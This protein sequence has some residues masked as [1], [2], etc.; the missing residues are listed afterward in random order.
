M[1]T[2]LGVDG[3]RAGWLVL[4]WRRPGPEL[5]VEIAPDWPAVLA[6]RRRHDAALVAVDMPIG[7]ADSGPRHCDRAARVLLPKGRKSCVFAAPR[8]YMLT[9]EDWAEAQALG[10]RREGVGLSKQAWNITAKIADIDRAIAPADQAVVREA[11]P[12]LVFHHLNGWQALPPKRLAAGRAARLALL[13][14]AG[15]T[16]IEA[17]LDRLPR[18]KAGADDVIDAAACALAARRILAGTATRVPDTPARDPHGLRMEI[19]F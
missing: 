5:Q 17:R 11:H 19:W 4:A 13:E 8:R 6:A 3:C 9:C 15:I 10:R 1:T 14:T 18:A 2:V 16:G 12:E 7:L